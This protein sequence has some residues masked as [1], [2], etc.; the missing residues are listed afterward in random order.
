MSAIMAAMAMFTYT[1]KLEPAEEGGYSVLVPALPG[2]VTQGETYEEA[3][4]MAKEAIRLYLEVLIEEGDP[5]PE[6]PESTRALAVE[7]SI[8]VPTH[9]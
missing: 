1:V 2:C 9:Q 5:V 6:E 4:A 8:D 7:V 3:I